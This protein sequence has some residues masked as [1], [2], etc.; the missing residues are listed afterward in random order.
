MGVSLQIS[1]PSFFQ[2]VKK[3]WQHIQKFDPKEYKTVSIDESEAIG[4]IW[5][6]KKF[7]K[8]TRKGLATL[9]INI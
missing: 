6:K 7:R 5:D 1:S 4:K 3:L 2:R 9:F 8:A